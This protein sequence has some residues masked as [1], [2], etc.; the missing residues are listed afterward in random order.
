MADEKETKNFSVIFKVE[1]KKKA[2]FGARSRSRVRSIETKKLIF[3]IRYFIRYIFSILVYLLLRKTFLD[4][5][6]IFQLFLTFSL[7][8]RRYQSIRRQ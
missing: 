1:E 5:S 4:K 2:I 3:C 8:R 6:L 7:R